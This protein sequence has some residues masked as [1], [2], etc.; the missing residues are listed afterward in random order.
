MLGNFIGNAS[1]LE[2]L[3]I[4]NCF[5]G[6]GF[7]VRNWREALAD[8][9][10]VEGLVNGRRTIAVS[11]LIIETLIL[12]KFSIF[13]LLGIAATAIP[14]SESGSIVGL[15][16]GLGFLIATVLLTAISAVNRHTTQY[17]MTYGIHTGPETQD[18]A[19]DRRFGEA[20]RALEVEHVEEAEVENG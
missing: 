14:S 1:F 16:F 11:T 8:Y 17:L 5:I 13:S 7:S 15:V 12:C 6:I 18:Q 20:R 10:T 2:L 3:W 4:L 19:E 9:S